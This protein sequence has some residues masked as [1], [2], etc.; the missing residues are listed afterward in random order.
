MIPRLWGGSERQTVYMYK[1]A[2]ARDQD[3]LRQDS[4]P[5]EITQKHVLFCDPHVLAVNKVHR[6]EPVS[7]VIVFARTD[8]QSLCQALRS[9]Q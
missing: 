4:L 7:G 3:L 9:V 2:K 1:R 6:L 8:R 5:R